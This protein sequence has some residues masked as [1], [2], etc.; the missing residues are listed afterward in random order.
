LLGIARTGKWPQPAARAPA[1]NNRCDFHTVL[2]KTVKKYRT[3]GLQG[4]S[5][6]V[7]GPNKNL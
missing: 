4:D 5:C 2:R 6:T 1:Q 3:L 7:L